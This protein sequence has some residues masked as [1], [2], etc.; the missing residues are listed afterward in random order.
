MTRR[1]WNALAVMAVLVNVVV[2][3][4]GLYR[5]FAGVPLLSGGP[6]SKAA[7]DSIAAL[8]IPLAAAALLKPPLAQSRVRSFAALVARSVV[9]GI[10]GFAAGLVAGLIVGRWGEMTQGGGIAYAVAAGA[11]FVPLILLPAV[12]YVMQVTA[13]SSLH[14]MGI[15]AGAILLQLAAILAAIA[16]TLVR[17]LG[18]SRLDKGAS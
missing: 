16:V 15:S 9:V 6:A 8:V 11:L 17:L 18:R 4:R 5:V 3:A 7:M 2:A 12:L 14:V 1:V 10:T 13:P